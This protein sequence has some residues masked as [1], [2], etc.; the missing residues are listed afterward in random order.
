[1]I[2][3]EGGSISLNKPG[4]IVVKGTRTFTHLKAGTEIGCKGGPTIT[5]PAGGGNAAAVRGPAPAMHLELTRLPNG[6][7]RVSCSRK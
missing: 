1:M 5:V 4:P 6:S 2:T 3:T 7:A